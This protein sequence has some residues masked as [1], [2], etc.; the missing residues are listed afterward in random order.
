MT[1]GRM[2]GFPQLLEKLEDFIETKMGNIYENT[3]EGK[4]CKEKY[5]HM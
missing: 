5:G 3:D 4:K 1:L 2:N